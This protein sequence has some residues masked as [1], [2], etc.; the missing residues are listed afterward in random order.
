MDSPD[1][2]GC[3][4]IV[5]D[6][7]IPLWVRIEECMRLL[8]LA[9]A[10]VKARGHRMVELEAAYYTAKA[11]ESFL[12]LEDGQTSTFIQTVIKG[13]ERV[14]EAMS[15]YHA[16]EVEYKNAQEAINAYKLKLRVLEA[17]MEREW[18]AQERM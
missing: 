12:L 7:S 2:T 9:L 4:P 16:A 17:E 6:E 10:E 5:N 3:E 15:G 11:Q 1:E 13:R 8:D 18:G 14:S